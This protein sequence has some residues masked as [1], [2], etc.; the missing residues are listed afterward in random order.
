MCIRGPILNF[1]VV[2]FSFLVQ[3]WNFR[4]Q[5]SGK[6]ETY[7]PNMF[8]STLISNQPP[9]C[10]HLHEPTMS[11]KPSIPKNWPAALPYLRIPL[12]S[13]HLTSSQLT[14]LRS[15]PASSLPVPIS[16]PLGPCPLVKIMPVTDRAHP[17]YGQSGLFAAKDLPAGSFILCYMGEIHGAETGHEESD[18]DLS[19]D[20][21]TGVA[22]DASRAG[23]EARFVNDYRGVPGKTGPNAEF[24]EVWDG[25][26]GER[27]MG[28]WVL[29]AGKAGKNK[30]IKKGE[31]ILI[32]YGRGFW[33][34]RKE[35]EEN[36]NGE[37][38]GV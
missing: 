20:R 22:V 29:A 2:H 31:E 26:R 12:Y 16:T 8:T 4:L 11:S 6:S 38:G 10:H 37:F 5:E 25:R 23:N 34:A 7:D 27:A 14:A 21:D 1:L 18:Y 30:G 15:A 17:A 32:S 35:E 3:R 28:V 36:Q 9:H 33:G 13:R 19:I 24:K